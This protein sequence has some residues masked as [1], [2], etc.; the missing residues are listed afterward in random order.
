MARLLTIDR[1]RCQN[2]GRRRKEL[3][4]PGAFDFVLR[5]PTREVLLTLGERADRPLAAR[6]AG[7][8][9]VG[10]WARRIAFAID[11]LPDTRLMPGILR[12]S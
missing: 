3:V 2:T 1:K 12:R 7:S 4:R 6:L 10:G 8:L 9:A 5:D 11:Q